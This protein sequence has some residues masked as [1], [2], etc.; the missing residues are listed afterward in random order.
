MTVETSA[1]YINELNETYP[2][3]EDL[4]KEGDDHLRLLKYVLKSSFPNVTS[5]IN[6]SSTKLNYL[7]T[8]FT[9]PDRK[10]VV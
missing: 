8:A 9:I 10:S 5:A 1:H 6:V 4:I 3:K 2:R 7:D